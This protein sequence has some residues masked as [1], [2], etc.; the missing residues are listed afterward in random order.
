MLNE[1]IRV[2]YC[3]YVVVDCCEWFDEGNAICSRI[4][5]YLV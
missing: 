1:S 4:C 3:S 5:C 2:E